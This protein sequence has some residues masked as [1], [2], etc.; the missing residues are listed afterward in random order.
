MPF[1]SSQQCKSSV[2]HGFREQEKAHMVREKSQLKEIKISKMTEVA[3]WD[4]K[5]PK[6][7]AQGNM[8]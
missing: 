1:L 8:V 5:P 2:Q 4:V 3:E 6:Q 7:R